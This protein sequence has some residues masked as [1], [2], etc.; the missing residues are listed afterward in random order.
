MVDVEALVVLGKQGF[1][2]EGVLAGALGFGSLGALGALGTLGALGALGTP[3][4]PHCSPTGRRTWAQ[5]RR[6]AVDTT[7][8]FNS[9]W[10]RVVPH[11]NNSMK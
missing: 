10:T 11:H 2:S 6:A 4:P 1:C 5:K 9:S 8:A 3:A 7:S